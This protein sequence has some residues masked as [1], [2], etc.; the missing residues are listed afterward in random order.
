MVQL[1]PCRVVGGTV[2]RLC[3]CFV[4]IFCDEIWDFVDFDF[5]FDDKSK[6]HKSHKVIMSC[7]RF[8]LFFC[9]FSPLFFLRFSS[10]I[11]CLIS[12]VLLLLLLLLLLLFGIYSPVNHH[13]ITVGTTHQC[14]PNTNIWLSALLNI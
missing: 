4:M 2:N 11:F 5:L 10:N 8:A 3:C 14:G 9:F 12:D 7:G 1:V 6:N 13:N